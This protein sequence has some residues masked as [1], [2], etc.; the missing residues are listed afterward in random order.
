MAGHA[1]FVNELAGF[2]ALLVSV[3]DH[4][5]FHLFSASD[6]TIYT[7]L[8]CMCLLIITLLVH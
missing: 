8:A 1:S 2:L 5:E 7:S 6:V 3:L 4:R